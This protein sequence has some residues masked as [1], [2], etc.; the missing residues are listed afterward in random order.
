MRPLGGVCLEF[1]EP[2]FAVADR[3][4]ECVA[5]VVGLCKAEHAL[6]FGD[7]SDDPVPFRLRHVSILGNEGATDQA[8]QGRRLLLDELVQLSLPFAGDRED[9]LHHRL[10]ALLLGRDEQ[11]LQE[12][13]VLEQSGSCVSG[14]RVHT[15]P[16]TSG[17]AVKRIDESVKA[18]GYAQ[19]G[20]F[21]NPK[22]AQSF[23]LPP[24]RPAF[25][26][27]LSRGGPAF[28]LRQRRPT[29]GKNRS[30][31]LNHDVFRIGAAWQGFDHD[32]E[33]IDVDTD[34]IDLAHGELSRA[35]AR[36]GVGRFRDPAANAV[37]FHDHVVAAV[38]D[39]VLDFREDMVREH[40]EVGRVGADRFVGLEVER[41]RLRALRAGALTE[42]VDFRGGW[43]AAKPLD[44]FVDVA[45]QRLVGAEPELPGSKLIVHRC[46]PRAPQV[47]GGWAAGESSR[48]AKVQALR[49][50]LSSSSTVARIA[51]GRARAPARR[52][53][54]GGVGVW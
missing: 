42:E 18:A 2:L 7:A 53:A 48:D 34:G 41:D 9:G 1:G 31:R 14:P 43:F 5:E 25:R 26:H 24:P 3:K 54:A 49:E 52:Q 21:V 51:S 32:L 28:E 10:V 11:S 15:W 50:G 23:P 4:R 27:P 6:E 39:D 8:R 37:F 35:L 44:P 40:N 22:P 38:V 20:E 19:T 13:E 30:A 16:C 12:V 47:A 45:K 46:A 17:S 36:T 33:Q 29:I